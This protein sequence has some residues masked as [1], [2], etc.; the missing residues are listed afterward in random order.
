[1]CRVFIL[2]FNIGHIFTDVAF[3]SFCVVA[4]SGIPTCIIHECR[5]RLKVCSVKLCL[6]YTK[7][8]V[9]KSSGEWTK[10]GRSVGMAVRT[11]MNSSTSRCM[12]SIVKISNQFVENVRNYPLHIH[13]V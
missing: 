12:I 13:G 2:Q 5:E 3:D 9:T 10:N 11:G 6:D 7:I 4:H 1:M 8:E